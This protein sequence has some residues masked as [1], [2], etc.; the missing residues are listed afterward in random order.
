MENININGTAKEVG[1]RL[2]SQISSADS[3]IGALTAGARG[4][5]YIL[6]LEACGFL[7]PSAVENM[8]VLFSSALEER[9]HSLIL[10]D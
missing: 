3:M 10:V 9:L 8:H 5:G 2:L 7:V 1:E 4:E 6:G